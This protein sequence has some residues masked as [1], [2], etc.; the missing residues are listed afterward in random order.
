M[1]HLTRGQRYEIQMGEEEA[2][3]AARERA[4]QKVIVSTKYRLEDRYLS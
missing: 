1:K 2:K 3:E 4:K